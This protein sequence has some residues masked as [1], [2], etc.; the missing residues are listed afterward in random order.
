MYDPLWSQGRGAGGGAQRLQSQEG[1]KSI[2]QICKICFV[3]ILIIL[4]ILQ[5]L[6]WYCWA[7]RMQNPKQ[8]GNLKFCAPFKKRTLIGQNIVGI[9]KKTEKDIQISSVNFVNFSDV[10]VW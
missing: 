5:T 8:P 9:F 1:R 7:E 6:S 3:I 2:L 4:S 10:A